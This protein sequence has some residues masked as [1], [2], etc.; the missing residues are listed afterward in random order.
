GGGEGGVADFGGVA[1]GVGEDLGDVPVGVVVGVDR[2]V[3]GGG[4]AGR[5]E[6]AGGGEDRVFGV[7]RA[8]DPVPVG[9]DS[10]F[11]P[12]RGHELHPALGAGRG[13]AEVGAE[14]GLDRV[15]PGE[16]RRALGAEPGFRRGALGDR[17][18]LRRH[19]AGGA[20]RGQQGQDRQRRRGF[21][22]AFG[23]DFFGRFVGFE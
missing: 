3:G 6:V 4:H 1:T 17:D 19:R 13:G 11:G 2:A 21:V 16:D 22:A 7:G 23:G 18:Q 9:V 10:P 12:G 5:G 15:D 14:A 8:G 20:G